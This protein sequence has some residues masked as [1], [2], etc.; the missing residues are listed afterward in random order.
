MK[1]RRKISYSDKNP[2]FFKIPPAFVKHFKSGLPLRFKLTS[3][4]K[5]SCAVAMNKI[6]DYLYFQKGWLKVVEDNSLEAGD[7]LI[8]CFYASKPTVEMRC[9]NFLRCIAARFGPLLQRPPIPSVQS[10]STP[11]RLAAPSLSQPHD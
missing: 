4:A 10:A 8:F 11:L 2:Q 9:H 3:P 7:F 5:S 6:E 1:P